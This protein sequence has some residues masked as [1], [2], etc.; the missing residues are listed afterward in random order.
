M[1]NKTV[2]IFDEF[3]FQFENQEL[4]N[5]KIKVMSLEANSKL[6]ILEEFV[7][8]KN[9]MELTKDANDKM[10]EDEQYDNFDEFRNE[11]TLLSTFLSKKPRV[12]LQN[13]TIKDLKKGDLVLIDDNE[14]E[15]VIFYVHE[16]NIEANFISGHPV[17]ENIHISSDQSVILK[18][19]TNSLNTE[20]AVLAEYTYRFHYSLINLNGGYLGYVNTD[21]VESL[22]KREAKELLGTSFKY[23]KIKEPTDPRDP[24]RSSL[25]DLLNHY[26]SFEPE[27]YNKIRKNSS[28]SAIQISKQLELERK[29]L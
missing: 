26:A 10:I 28:D 23:K 19:F 16:N 8:N 5:F 21:I 27:Q 9:S 1:K 22:Q 2:S 15:S 6:D 3:N 13:K 24:Y 14:N 29:F 18:D 17:V 11:L 25:L 20:L 4:D 7:E 12:Y